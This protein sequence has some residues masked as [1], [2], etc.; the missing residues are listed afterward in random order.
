MA[1]REHPHLHL[2]RDLRGPRGRPV[3]PRPAR[4]RDIT[5]LELPDDAAALLDDQHLT[6]KTFVMW[7]LIHDRTHMRGDLPLTR[8]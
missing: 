5:S 1:V 7:D 8:S 4:R 2:G 6:E 3:P